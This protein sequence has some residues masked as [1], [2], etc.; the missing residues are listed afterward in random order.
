MYQGNILLG[1]KG[2]SNWSLEHKTD[3]QLLP[4]VQIMS[5]V[6]EEVICDTEIEKID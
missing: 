6:F 5:P 1:E 4:T 3:T 2:K